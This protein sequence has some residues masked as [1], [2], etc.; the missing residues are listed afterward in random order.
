M[1]F[2]CYRAVIEA[3]RAVLNNP[4]FEYSQPSWVRRS[5][6]KNSASK[7]ASATEH[8]GSSTD[9]EVHPLIRN[10]ES[11]EEDIKTEFVDEA[12]NDKALL[13]MV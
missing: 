3:I 13:R 10:M 8:V 6:S 5:E 12:Q 4:A 11:E 2:C 7:P 9:S 1:V